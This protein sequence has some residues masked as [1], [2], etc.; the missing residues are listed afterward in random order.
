[1]A[2][3]RTRRVLRDLKFKDGN[4]ACFECNS[5]NPQWVSVSYGIW[6]CLDCSGKHRGLGV[7][8]S[9]VRSVTMDKWKDIELEKMKVGGNAKAKEFFQSQSDYKDGMSLTEKYNSRAAALYRDKIITEAEGNTWSEATSNSRNYKPPFAPTNNS[10]LK[11]NNSLGSKSAPTIS[12]M[13]DLETFLGKSKAEISKDKDDYFKKKQQE[14]DS[15]SENLP[16]SQGGKYIGF[17]SSPAPSSKSEAGWDTTLATLQSGLSSFT[18]TAQQMASVAS[19]KAIKLGS[20][21]NE[22]YIK[23]ASHK[24]QELTLNVTAK[25]SDGRLVQDV[26]G[27]LQSV[28]G[29]AQE[30][31][32][33]GWYNLQS[34]I[35]YNNSAITNQGEKTFI[36]SAKS[37]TK[38]EHNVGFYG[39][40]STNNGVNPFQEVVLKKQDLTHS[41]EDSGWDS[42]E[43]G[44][45]NDWDDDSNPKT[46]V[47]SEKHNKNNGTKKLMKRDSWGNDPDEWENWL[48][49]DTNHK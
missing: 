22:N 12:S 10:S 2:S 24:A 42:A 19:A 16:P 32:L 36:N 13:D 18:V 6:I 30:Y 15:K 25:A 38:Q 48:N 28:A 44:S 9:F 43:W 47:T 41:S 11:G 35:G 5:H 45:S 7:H 3:P 4:N 31:G 8:L 14:N 40:D 17:G 23:P 21:V 34:Y 39:G 26:S 46:N 29:K 37:Q 20:K 49:D 27:T 33:K 1:M